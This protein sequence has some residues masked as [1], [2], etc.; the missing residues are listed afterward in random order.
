MPPHV[1]TSALQVTWLTP[2]AMGRQG[3]FSL[4]MQPART[5][6]VGLSSAGYQGPTLVLLHPILNQSIMTQVLQSIR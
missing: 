4:S 6:Q 3:M 1:S 2:V 5:F